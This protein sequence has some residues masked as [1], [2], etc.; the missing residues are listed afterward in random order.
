MVLVKVDTT[1]ADPK[2]ADQALKVIGRVVSSAKRREYAVNGSP[3]R[4]AQNNR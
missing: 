2:N 3:N 1:K 4:S